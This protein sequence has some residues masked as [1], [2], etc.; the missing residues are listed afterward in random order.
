MATAPQDAGADLVPLASLPTSA[1]RELFEHEREAWLERLLWD[2]RD[3]AELAASAVS[4]H[5]IDGAA[6]CH[7]THWYGFLA[8]QPARPVSRLCGGWLGPDA[9]GA[10]AARLVG[11]ALKRLP[12]GVRVEGQVIAFSAQRH[13]DAGFRR[14]GFAAE[15]RRY[16]IARLPPLP[17][18]SAHLEG[19][20]V[21]S[22]D[23]LLVSD[24]A[25]VLVAAH[26]SGV[27][28]RINASFR[29]ERGASEYLGDI[30]AGQGCGDVVGEASLAAVRDGRVVGFC[31]GT[32][33]SPGVGHVPQIAVDPEAQ[34]SGLGA[35]LLGSTFRALGR[36]GA[37][38]VTLSVSAAN[39]RAADWYARLGFEPATDFS[40]YHRDG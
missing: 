35:L 4:S 10:A 33:I 7:G 15:P 16:L 11:E 22:V 28:A 39:A 12:R 24:C 1:V 30:L 3:A 9:D 23:A 36:R 2:T 5:I 17:V 21:L 25:R 31:L 19:V 26:R 32:L 14:H 29:T 40:A 34:G 8:L 37:R 6:L 38:K 18:A 27:E 20:R 13:F